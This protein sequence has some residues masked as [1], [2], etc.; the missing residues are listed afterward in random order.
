[1]VVPARVYDRRRSVLPKDL[2]DLSDH[3]WVRR[4][5]IL[6]LGGVG[7]EIEELYGA[8]RGT[9]TACSDSFPLSSFIFGEK[10]RLDPPVPMKLPRQVSVP[11]L[12]SSLESRKKGDSFG[13]IF[14][15]DSR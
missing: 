2:L 4:S 6:R 10:D 14:S 9:V 11:R 15:G 3:I 7:S 5:E 13:L 8:V 1:L 12:F